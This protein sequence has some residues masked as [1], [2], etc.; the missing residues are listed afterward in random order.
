MNKITKKITELLLVA[1]TIAYCGVTS[2]K[3][4]EQHQITYDLDGGNF[5]GDYPTSARWYQDVALQKP[6]K[7]KYIFRGWSDGENILESVKH[8]RNDVFLKA[9]YTPEVYA[10]TFKNGDEVVSRTN[11]AY[12]SEVADLGKFAEGKDFDKDYEEFDCWVDSQG[13]RVSTLEAGISGNQELTAK[14]KG[15]TYSIEYDLN[16]GSADGLPD[17]YQY[18]AGVES[19]PDASAEGKVFD[20]WF[21]DAEFTEAADSI[22]AD[23]HG[24]RHLYAKFHDAPVVKA[25]S[26]GRSYSRRSA[27]S[28]STSLSSGNYNYSVGVTI[29][30]MGYH[31]DN[32]GGDEAIDAE[33]AIAVETFGIEYWQHDDG[34]Y[35]CFD[36]VAG[37][38]T[39]GLHRAVKNV[40]LLGDHASQGLSNLGNLLQPGDKLYLNGKEYTYSGYCNICL[41][42]LGG[43]GQQDFLENG[44][45]LMIRTCTDA[46]G[47]S[48]Y[49][50]F[51]Y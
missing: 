46:S 41:D 17:T 32:T 49:C 29:P 8:A 2:V 4:T 35:A 12:G 43:I 1:A 48:N 15:K 28:G 26:A 5:T 13:N 24:N 44:Y 21:T 36:V 23:S 50:C 6:E 10:V 42:Y 31:V 37:E 34:S 33:N 18:G 16:G 20:G 7:K 30:R 39:E 47:T 45:N 22:S 14:L 19:F 40:L 38:S 25:F 3:A 27:Y 9:T 51:F 11:Y